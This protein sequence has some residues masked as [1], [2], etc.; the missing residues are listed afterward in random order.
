MFEDE[1][2]YFFLR[3]KKTVRKRRLFKNSYSRINS[4]LKTFN[5]RLRLAKKESNSSYVA[6]DFEKETCYWPTD[7]IPLSDWKQFLWQTLS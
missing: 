3:V 5:H 1:M 6:V 7:L 2:K 4:S